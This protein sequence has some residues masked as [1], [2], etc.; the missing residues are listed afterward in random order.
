MRTLVAAILA[1]EKIDAVVHFAAESHVD[2]SITGPEIFVRPMFS[3]PR[4]CWKRA[5]SIG[6]R[7]LSPDFRFLQ[8]STDE[9]YGSLGD[10]GFF[11]E[12]TPLAANSPYSASKAGADLLVRAYHETY[13]LPTLNTRCSNNYGPYHFP[14]KLIPAPD[15]QHHRQK[16]RCRSTATA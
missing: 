5:A 6:S 16:S 12:E 11:T 4:F 2:R 14:E 13:G 9:V 3:A 7:V 10:T 1:E 15:P 8:I